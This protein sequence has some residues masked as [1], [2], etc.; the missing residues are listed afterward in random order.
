MKERGK[1]LVKNRDTEKGK[2]SRGKR[3]DKGSEGGKEI[4]E[5]KKR[6]GGN[7]GRG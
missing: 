5:E 7:E 2:E 4:G 6:R 3:G 1:E